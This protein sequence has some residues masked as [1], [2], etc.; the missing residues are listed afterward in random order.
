MNLYVPRRL[1]R[2]QRNQNCVS[3]WK[4]NELILADLIERFQIPRNRCIEFGVEF[5]FSTVAF[6][7]YFREVIGVDTFVGDLHTNHQGDHYASTAGSLARYPNIKLV[8]AD[9][10]DYI[11]EAGDE[12]FD[13]AHVDIVHTYDHTFAC[14]KW[15]AERSR[16]TLFH[17]T[18]LFPDVRRA[19][20]DIAAATGKTFY[21]Y[22]LNYGLG[23]LV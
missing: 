4:G 6:S 12:H 14:G 23:I 8:Q 2:P 5:G 9:Y 18:E 19:V 16:C 3:A 10:R 13:L 7:D 21:N 11:R 15:C 17:D 1:I 22:P 20:I